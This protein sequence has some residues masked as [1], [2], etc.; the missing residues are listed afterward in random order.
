MSGLSAWR[1]LLYVPAHQLKMVRGAHKRGADAIIL[2]L[3]DGVPEDAKEAARAALKD[4]VPRVKAGGADALVRINKP[5]S[6]AWRDVEA[7]VEAGASALLLP[8]AEDACQASVISTYLDELSPETGPSTVGL[9]ALIESARGLNRVSEIAAASLRL[10]A[11]IPGNEDLAVD[12][13]IRPEPERMLHAFLPVLLAARAQGIRVYGTLGGS[14]N[15][16]DLEGYRERVKLS[17]AW[18]F[19]GTTCIHPSQ[20]Q[21]INEIYEPE[22]AELREAE[23]IVEIFEASGG[24]PVALEGKMV[25]RPV[26]LRAKRMLEQADEP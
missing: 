10:H 1:S 2:D 15:F 16:R 21:V 6:L 19:S 3:E 18:G 26:Y 7:A 23:R 20:V 11:L 13:G 4:A 9:L 5:W 12:L 17:K 22:E 14:A 25:D 8:K 24:N